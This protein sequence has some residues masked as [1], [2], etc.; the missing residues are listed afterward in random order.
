MMQCYS[1]RFDGDFQGK[2]K[3]KILILANRFGIKKKQQK[4]I[5]K[6]FKVT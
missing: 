3:R 4:Y 1:S 2:K 5:N 6:V